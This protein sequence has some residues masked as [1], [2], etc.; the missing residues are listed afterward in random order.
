MKKTRDNR[1]TAMSCFII[2]VTDN[3]FFILVLNRD[4]ALTYIKIIIF[5]G[6]KNK[7]EF[8]FTCLYLNSLDTFSGTPC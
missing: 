3:V 7:K 2:I 1:I 8:C 5:E 6:E 4:Y